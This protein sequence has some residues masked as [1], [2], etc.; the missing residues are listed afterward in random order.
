[1]GSKTVI[2][3]DHAYWVPDREHGGGKRHKC[4]RTVD[5]THNNTQAAER[6]GWR[7]GSQRARNLD[8]TKDLCPEHR[9]LYEDR[10]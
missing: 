9:L 3:C 7:M 10:K 5:G 2:T 6:A 4:A 8:E 1:M